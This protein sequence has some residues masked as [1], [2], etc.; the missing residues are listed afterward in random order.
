MTE[1][2]GQQKKTE[3][4]CTGFITLDPIK[5]ISINVERKKQIMIKIKSFWSWE[6]V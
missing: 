6:M 5:T 1:T 3:D 2:I 4:K